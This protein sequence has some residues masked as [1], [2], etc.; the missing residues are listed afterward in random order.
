MCAPSGRRRASCL[1]PR[2]RGAN[3]FSL[4]S[5][6]YPPFVLPSFHGT[7]IMRPTLPI[8]LAAAVSVA[9]AACTW[10][11]PI[12]SPGSEPGCLEA[13]YDD[14][15]N[16]IIPPGVDT[17]TTVEVEHGLLQTRHPEFDTS[18]D[19]W[20][21]AWMLQDCPT[22]GGM[23]PPSDAGENP[24][25]KQDSAAAAMLDSLGPALSTLPPPPLGVSLS[26]ISAVPG[27]RMCGSV[28]CHTLVPTGSPFHGADIIYVHGLL[29]KPTEEVLLGGPAKPAWPTDAADF[30]SPGGYWRQQAQQYWATHVSELL[31]SRGAKNRVL[32]VGWSPLQPL[33]YAAHTVLAQI[34]GAMHT[35]TGVI[36]RDPADPRGQAGFCQ[37]SCVIV[38]HSTGGLVTDVAMS[39]AAQPL[40]APVPYVGAFNGLGWVPARMRVQVAL[41][42]PFSGSQYAT[43]AMALAAGLA[44]SVSPLCSPG[45]SLL[46]GPLANCPNYAP[47]LNSVVRDLM[48]AVA[49]GVWGPLVATTPVHV[50]TIAGGHEDN[51]WP[52]KR[53][54]SA[55][56]D[57]GV[58]NMDSGCGRSVPFVGWPTGYAPAAWRRVYD[59]GISNGRAIRYFSEQKFEPMWSPTQVPRASAACS[60]WK[61]PTGM[62]QPV[63]QFLTTAVNP[64]TYYPRH[65][66]FVQTAESHRN[67]LRDCHE[68][69]AEDALAIANHLPYSL[70]GSGIANLQEETVRRKPLYKKS[71]RSLWKRTYHQL[72]GWSSR[73]A[74][75]YAYDWVL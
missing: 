56:F 10:L 13:E 3:P 36:L 38:S 6:P 16:P 54:F 49:Q 51:K 55:G 62:V 63:S 19:E 65:H 48:P 73:C 44:P 52:A 75:D 74:V 9:L 37:P 66:P 58:V 28:L 46:S 67:G 1:L 43:A 68:K 33:P 34:A 18:T 23:E 47:L 72:Q 29:V 20:Y 64:F 26:P 15:G 25:A 40:A 32:F 39:L 42:V 50:L 24:A 2:Q 60:V 53:V 7:D 70:V 11:N 8:T 27:P 22:L 69:G 35:G 45:S 4:A 30:L 41:G 31:D 14:R 12:P 71:P 59:L 5:L 17:S 57:D 61:S 21:S